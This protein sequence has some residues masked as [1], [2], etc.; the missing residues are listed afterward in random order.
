[1]LQTCPLQSRDTA[2]VLLDYAA[3]RL[4]EDP[5]LALERHMEFCAECRQFVDQQRALWKAL[6]RWDAEPV[7]LE[8]QRRF[9]QRAERAAASRW[10]AGISLKPAIPLAVLAVFLLAAPPRAAMD[11]PPSKEAQAAEATEQ[12]LEDLDLLSQLQSQMK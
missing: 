3:R 6:D 8:F 1:M 12:V 7:S 11:P 2:A 9:W 4:D 5:S 10:W